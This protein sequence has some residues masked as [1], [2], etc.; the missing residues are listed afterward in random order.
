MGAR[1]MSARPEGWPDPDGRIAA[2]VAAVPPGGQVS[3]RAVAEAAGAA[4]EDTKA[5]VVVLW[6]RGELRGEFVAFHR[7]CDGRLGPERCA[8]DE[9]EEDVAA[10]T[11]APCPSCGVTGHD[12][13][14]R[15]VFYAPDA[16]ESSP[17]AARAS[18]A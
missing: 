9:A 11:V 6:L 14:V 12:A 10:A 7:P 17:T 15:V 2:A 8:Q 3:P 13:E 4:L 1:P 18:G 16:L 5:E